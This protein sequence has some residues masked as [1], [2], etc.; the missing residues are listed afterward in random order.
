MF[1]LQRNN[2]LLNFMKELLM[3]LKSQQQSKAVNPTL[4]NFDQLPNE[5]HI[6]PKICAEILGISI[7]TYWRLVKA[8]HLP[9][10]RLTERTTSTTAGALRAFIASKEGV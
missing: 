8:K 2:A 10:I 5:A 4:A 1:F 9:T 7:A 6:R 3:Q